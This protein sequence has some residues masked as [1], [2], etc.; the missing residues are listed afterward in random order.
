MQILQIKNLFQI[1]AVSLSS[2]FELLR[3]VSQSAPALLANVITTTDNCTKD[4][5]QKCFA[6]EGLAAGLTWT[7]SY[8]YPRKI[9]HWVG[10]VLPRDVLPREILPLVK[11]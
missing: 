2:L 4:L 3:Q 9:V 5:P 10:D 1:S 8:C 6:N 11:K 7:L